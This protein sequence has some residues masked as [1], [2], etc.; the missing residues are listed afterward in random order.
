MLESEFYEYDGIHPKVITSATSLVTDV[1]TIAPGT[2]NTTSIP[3]DTWGIHIHKT[4][5][6]LKEED[7]LAKYDQ[8]PVT[9][10]KKPKT[11]LI[12]VNTY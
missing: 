9:L 8:A 1:C 2:A 10:Q 5:S 4:S 12:T 6:E 11:K 7:A 3:L